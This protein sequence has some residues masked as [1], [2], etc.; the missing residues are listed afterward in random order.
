MID[1]KWDEL[2]TDL[3][4]SLQ[5]VATIYSADEPDGR[6]YGFAQAKFHPQDGDGTFHEFGLPQ[7][8]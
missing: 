4:S 2:L 5:D 7:H 6:A 8:T 1:E 3:R